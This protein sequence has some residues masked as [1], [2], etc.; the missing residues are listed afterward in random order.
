VTSQLTGPSPV[1]KSSIR[2]GSAT[3][4]I[5]ELSGTSSAPSATAAITARP[6]FRAVEVTA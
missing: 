5:V 6:P 3:A 2:S 4:T 1:W